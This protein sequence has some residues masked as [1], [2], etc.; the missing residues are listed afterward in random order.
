M[1]I[2]ATEKRMFDAIDGSRTIGDLLGTTAPSSQGQSPVD[3]ATSL[4]GCGGMTTSFSTHHSNDR[5]NA[6]SML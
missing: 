4:S 5:I 6:G 1:A 3:H 2:S